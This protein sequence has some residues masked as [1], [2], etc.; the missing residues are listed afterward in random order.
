[1]GSSRRSHLTQPWM[2]S[3]L[4][5]SWGNRFFGDVLKRITQNTPP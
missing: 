3:H 1:M 5:G 2:R 4:Y